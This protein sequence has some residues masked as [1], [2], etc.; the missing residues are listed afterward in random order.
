MGV[1]AR[2]LGV[3]WI[4]SGGKPVDLPVTDVEVASVRPGR[5]CLDCEVGWKGGPYCWSCGTDVRGQ[6]W[7]DGL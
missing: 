1:V 2:L 7:K 5:S 3:T 6:R 4:P